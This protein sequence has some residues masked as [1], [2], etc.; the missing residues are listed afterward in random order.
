MKAGCICTVTATETDEVK[1]STEEKISACLRKDRLPFKRSQDDALRAIRA[2]I[3]TGR[4][5]AMPEPRSRAVLRYAAAAAILVI[6]A[7]AGLYL[8]GKTTLTNAS[9]EIIVTHLPDGSKVSLNRGAE[10]DFNAH[11]FFL[12]RKVRAAGETFFEVNRGSSFTVYTEGGDVRVL[13]T[14]FNVRYV[15]E[16]LEV[17]CK[18]GR[19]AVNVPSGKRFELTPGGL[20]TANA[21]NVHIS[22][23][24]AAEIGYWSFPYYSFN[25]VPVKEVFK[26]LA[27]NIGFEIICGFETNA[28]YSGEFSGAQS[29]EDLLDI[30]CKPLGF[31][32]RIDEE[33]RTIT[34][35]NN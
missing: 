20:L 33:K 9:A 5:I 4:V 14:S 31:D 24:P 35:L 23:M 10:I 2:R 29:T 7:L 27:D 15:D 19:V 12:N 6:G 16:A 28:R 34:I 8:S 26:S 17:G 25:D 30:V 18:T 3:N 21:G 1:K 32:Y 13:G 22:E 11:T